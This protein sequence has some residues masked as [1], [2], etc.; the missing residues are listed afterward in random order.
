LWELELSWRSCSLE[1]YFRKNAALH[2]SD[3]TAPLH[4]AYHQLPTDKTGAT[5]IHFLGLHNQLVCLYIFRNV[6]LILLINTNVWNFMC[7]AVLAVTWIWHFLSCATK[8]E[9]KLT[10]KFTIQPQIKKEILL[11]NHYLSHSFLLSWIVNP[12]LPLAY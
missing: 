7:V 10:H 9:I 11:P 8:D 4:Y 6:Q 3:L 5:W 2:S 1:L 12:L